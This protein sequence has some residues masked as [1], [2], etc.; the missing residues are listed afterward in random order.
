MKTQ[1]KEILS[2]D[3]P[4]SYKIKY[5]MSYYTKAIIIG[6]LCLIGVISLIYSM[7]HK[8][9]GPELQV[10]VVGKDAELYQIKDVVKPED[11]VFHTAFTETK[12]NGVMYVFE[13]D[14]AYRQKYV[15]QLSAAELDILIA[16]D[17]EYQQMKD[18]TGL[19]DLSK[20]S[21][22]SSLVSADDPYGILL[23]KA[24]PDASVPEDIK[25]YHICVLTNS[26]RQAKAL[27]VLETFVK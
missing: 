26:K 18:Q 21:E 3:K 7:T 19:L 20:T 15:L 6:I 12:K 4:L 13:S 8:A 14:T 24:D 16:N 10:A 9:P 5:F 27:K 22:L 17:K 11:S 23:G 25:G 2:S 1:V